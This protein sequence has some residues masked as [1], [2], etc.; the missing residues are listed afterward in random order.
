MMSHSSTVP[1]IRMIS[2]FS[3]F[4]DFATHLFRLFSDDAKDL[5]MISTTH[6]IFQGFQVEN[7]QV[8]QEPTTE[9]LT[10]DIADKIHLL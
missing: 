2:S 4:S 1:L 7:I 9:C 10:E 5:Y 6:S 3:Y 8:K